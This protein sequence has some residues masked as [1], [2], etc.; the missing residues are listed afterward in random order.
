MDRSP[1]ASQ[2][3]SVSFPHGGGGDRAPGDGVTYGALCP[4]ALP[5]I[6]GLLPGVGV[7][8]PQDR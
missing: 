7:T 3:A 2:G 5:G 1:T 6:R 4:G 8:V